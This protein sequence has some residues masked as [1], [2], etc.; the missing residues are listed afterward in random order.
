MGLHLPS[1]SPLYVLAHCC[2][3]KGEFSGP[4]RYVPC[5]FITVQT[6]GD[7]DTIFIQIIAKYSIKTRAKR[8]N[9][10]HYVTN[11]KPT[12]PHHPQPL[13][14]ENHERRTTKPTTRFWKA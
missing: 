11:H 2:F 6:S 13:N 1:S 4:Y 7:K 5:I 10:P 14:Q 9:Q 12:N 8:A 3:L